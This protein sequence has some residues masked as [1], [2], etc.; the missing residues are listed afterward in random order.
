MKFRG[1]RT[2]RYL[3]KER[4]VLWGGIICSGRSFDWATETFLLPEGMR[5]TEGKLNYKELL[6]TAAKVKGIEDGLIYYPHLR[7]R[8]HPT[9]IQS[10][11]LSAGPAGYPHLSECDPC[12]SG[13]LSMQARRIIETEEAVAG[14]KVNSVCVVGGSSKN[15]LWQQIKANV[16]QKDV[17]LCHE[18]EATSLGAA[19]LAAIGDGTYDSIEQVSDI[20]ACRNQV[21][22]RKSGTIT[23]KPISCSVTD[24]IS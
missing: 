15:L 22:H 16:L 3:Q 9:G 23:K 17:E 7:E 1:Q 4:Y 21:V 2:C 14:V 11:R 18:P 8:E 5:S 20:L 19:M 6:D 24:T 10:Q 12:C 13:G